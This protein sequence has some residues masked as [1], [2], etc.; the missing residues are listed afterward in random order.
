MLVR[1]KLSYAANHRER[2]N[3]LAD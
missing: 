3:W 2:I 1:N